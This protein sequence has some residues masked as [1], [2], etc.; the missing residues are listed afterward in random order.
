MEG[1]SEA[2]F[3]HKSSKNEFP[4]SLYTRQNQK[5]HGMTHVL[6]GFIEPYCPATMAASTASEICWKVAI[7]PG[8]PTRTPFT[9][10]VGVPLT[11]S[12]FP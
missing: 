12:S 10:T 4:N 8:S 7:F 3:R 2:M 5:G 11:P 6:F 9:K 1:G